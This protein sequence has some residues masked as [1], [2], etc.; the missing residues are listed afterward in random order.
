MIKTGSDERI[1]ESQSKEY[2]PNGKQK[3]YR[4]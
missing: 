3:A 2:L 1:R 4:P